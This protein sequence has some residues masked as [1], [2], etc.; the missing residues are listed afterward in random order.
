[1]E[2]CIV[3]FD[4]YVAARSLALTRFAY[5]LTGD[6]HLAEDLVQSALLKAFRHWGKVAR[7]DSPDAYVRR[8]V[9]NTHLSWRRRLRLPEWPVAAPPD[10]PTGGLL[11][12]PAD[13]VGERDVLHRALTDLPPR[14]RT[15][16]VLRHYAGYDDADI[17]RTL[18]CTEAAVRGYASKG[19]ARV[20]AALSISYQEAPDARA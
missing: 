4:E 2:G 13:L 7:A 9:V 3:T 14:Q 16:L 12:D 19:A 8:I 18:G 20:R 15:V 17:A 5:V 6:A 11:D 10:T 1:M